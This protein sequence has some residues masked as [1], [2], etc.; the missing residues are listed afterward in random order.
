MKEDLLNVSVSVLPKG[1][2]PGL[3]GTRPFGLHTLHD[4]KEEEAMRHRI[5]G[6]LQ[7]S[8]DPHTATLLRP[9]PRRCPRCEHSSLVRDAEGPT[10]ILCGYRPDGADDAAYTSRPRP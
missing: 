4:Y 7:G 1:R 9:D 10:C 8:P 5:H 2:G 3:H 6:P